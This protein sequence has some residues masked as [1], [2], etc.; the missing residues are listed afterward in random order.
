MGEN[1]E[2]ILKALRYIP[3]SDLDYGEWLSVG[4]AL[5]HEGFAASDWDDWS[6]ND[7]RYAYGEC[8]RKWDGLGTA[9]DPVTAGTIFKLAK[10]R[11]FEF[12][13]DRGE[14]LDWD[15]E[16][17]IEDENYFESQCLT[18]EPFHEPENFDPAEEISTYLKTLF[19]SGDNVGYV[20]ESWLDKRTGKLQ[21]T[22]GLC[23]RTAGELLSELAICEGDIGAVFGD[24]NPA[25]GAWIRINP[26]DGKG[27]KN[28][29]VTDFR[30]AL[31]ESDNLPLERQNAL[32]R[33]LELPVAVMVYSGGKSI[34]SVVR[35]DAANYE[36]YR[37]R[38]D[39]LFKTC[40]KYGF[41]IDKQNKNPSRLSRMPGVTR[42][43]KK[44]YIIDV[45]IGRG[46]FEEWQD[47]IEGIND[48][49][50]DPVNLADVW[51]NMPPLSEPL[52]DG[53]LR[54]G[55]KMLVAGPSKAGKSFALIELCIALAEGTDWLGFKCAQGK[56]FYINLELDEA[57]CFHRFADVYAA[58][59]LPAENFL[60]NIDVWNLR[61]KSVP[62]DELAPKLIRRAARQNYVAVIVDPIYKI[63]TGDEN[64]A[65]QMAKFC[66]QFDL[67]CTE[68]GCAVVYC[69]H[70]SKGLQGG[71]RSMDRASGSGVFA[72]DPD[73][74]L[75]L[76]ELAL[77]DTLVKQQDERATCEVCMEWF[78]RFSVDLENIPPDDLLSA[79]K[80]VEIA[81]NRLSN[82]SYKLMLQDVESAKKRLRRRTAW[83]IEGTLREFPKFEPLNLWFDYPVH[84]IDEVGVLHDLRADGDPETPTERRRRYAD[85]KK[86]REDGAEKGREKIQEMQ[87][88]KSKENIEKFT[89][90]YNEL[91]LDDT[92]PTMQEIAT[93]LGK[94][95][96]TVRDWAKKA[97]YH[98]DRS[99]RKVLKD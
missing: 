87:K 66:N 84:E 3:P 65:D 81:R 12:G 9:G 19:D 59:G 8:E 6:R 18:G 25:A 90:A 96:N 67:I 56:V 33:E 44:Q 10:E 62:L 53:V 61:G 30:Y 83:R 68:L 38:V 36:E 79:S 75:D 2:R 43:D 93:L 27:I 52:I 32:I 63:I 26:L 99:S 89:E 72:R 11:G 76:T 23:D 17:S 20:T 91:M 7:K 86:R 58:L 14:A 37:K 39:Y 80:T 29:N 13:Y 55:H 28:S 82:K 46:S 94:P 64:S 54:K 70:H 73:A 34:H 16:I 42:G 40:E 71:K 50:P 15:S 45:N 41:S 69:H 21:P 35:V 1:R 85:Y 31:V 74:L 78:R 95:L 47:Y 5:K 48:D 51:D 4:I 49:L 24:Y 57:S 92:P 88:Q 60:K 98:V 22:K 97:G 77:T